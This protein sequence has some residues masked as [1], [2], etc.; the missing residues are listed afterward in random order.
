[1][2]RTCVRWRLVEAGGLS[3]AAACSATSVWAGGGSP[4]PTGRH[5]TWQVVA[6]AGSLPHLPQPT[7]LA[8]DMLGTS[9]RVRG[10]RAIAY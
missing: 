3:A 1:M 4:S 5:P 7:G 6:G 9:A 10:L 2:T 8:I